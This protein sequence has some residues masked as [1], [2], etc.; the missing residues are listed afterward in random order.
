MTCLCGHPETIPTQG[1]G[2]CIG[3]IRIYI[4][5]VPDHVLRPGDRVLEKAEAEVVVNEAQAKADKAPSYL[6]QFQKLMN[7]G[8]IKMD[9]QCK[10]YHELP[11][12]AEETG[13]SLWGPDGKPIA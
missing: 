12:P 13:V 9:C 7:R 1:R 11:I 2:R 5:R 10:L 3:G 4:S 8:Y 6:D